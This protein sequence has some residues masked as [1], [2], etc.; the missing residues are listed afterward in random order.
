MKD[1][2][3]TN[4]HYLTYT[5][6]FGKV[7]RMY[8]L[9]LGV[10]GLK[11]REKVT[12][13]RPVASIQ[14]V[15]CCWTLEWRLSSLTGGGIRGTRDSRHGRTLPGLRHARRAQ[16]VLRDRCVRRYPFVSREST[17][18]VRTGA[19]R[20]LLRGVGEKLQRV[21][22]GSPPPKEVRVRMSGNRSVFNFF[23]VFYFQILKC[24]IPSS[25]SVRL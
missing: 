8:F 5:F 6:L 10:K 15:E 24:P 1:D 11:G 12:H 25:P 3:T 23:Y 20:T 14:I 17:F 13:A 18:W 22:R 16:D 4:S 9:N 21:P 2:Y 7:G 19:R